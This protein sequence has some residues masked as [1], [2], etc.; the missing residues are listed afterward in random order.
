MKAI[1]LAAGYATRLYPLTCDRPK[2]LL[3]VAGKPIINYIMD[4]L[5]TI[6]RIDTI[7]VVTN[8]KFA[9]NFNLW[10]SEYN[11][12]KKLKVIDDGTTN[13]DNRRGAIGDIQFVIE[14]ENINEELMII[15]G[16]NLFTFK[17]SKYMDFYIKTGGDCVCAKKVSDREALKELAVAVLDDDGRILSLVEKPE[18]PPSD[19]GVYAAYIYTQG[20]VGL[21]NVYLSEGNKPDAPGYFVQWLYKRKTVFAY[22]MDGECYDVGTHKSY[23]EVNKIFTSR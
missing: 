18:E 8:H 3:P 23:D 6:D 20:T 9:D 22:V 19:I 7:Y 12:P 1:I 16:D 4:E 17:L 21:F 5:E 13:E 11:C 2:A 14:H 10:A 15:A